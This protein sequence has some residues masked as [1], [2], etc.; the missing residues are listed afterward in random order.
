MIDELQSY[1]PT[2]PCCKPNTK[3]MEA[4]SKR[5]QPR[6]SMSRKRCFPRSKPWTFRGH[7]II[8][9]SN[10][11]PPTGTLCW[12]DRITTSENTH[13]SRKIHRQL[14][15]LMIPPRSGPS[16]AAVATSAPI[17]AEIQ[18]STLAG[19]IS[20]RTTKHIEY[21]PDPPIPWMVL[22]AINMRREVDKPHPID[23]A[24]NIT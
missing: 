12:S 3:R 4:A 9:T 2:P 19:L 6:K 7:A 11:T 18:G 23:M 1:V 5:K 21:M 16:I 20:G 8:R 10:A 13:L 14:C 15:S 24:M 22:N 17:N